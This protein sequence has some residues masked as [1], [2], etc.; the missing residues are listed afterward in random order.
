VPRGTAR[1]NVHGWQDRHA[2]YTDPKRTPLFCYCAHARQPGCLPG[3]PAQRRELRIFVRRR[4]QKTRL[5]HVRRR[6]EPDR[7]YMR[8]VAYTCSDNVVPFNG[9]SDVCPCAQPSVCLPIWA[10]QKWA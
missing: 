2:E 4:I 1:I 3:Q 8:G 9:V 5:D 10:Q 7:G 6:R